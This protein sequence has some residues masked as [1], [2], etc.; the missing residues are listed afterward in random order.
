MDSQKKPVGWDIS[1]PRTSGGWMVRADILW[2][3]TIIVAL[4]A[5]A[6]TFSDGLQYMVHDWESEEYSHGYL[7]PIIAAFLIWRKKDA[8]ASAG[9]LRA[10]GEGR[11]GPRGGWAGVVL[12]FFGLL[13]TL[14]GE[15]STAVKLVQ[16]G[17]IIVLFGVAL[18]LTG[19]RGFAVIAAPM[20]YFAFM[21][22]LPDFLYTGLSGQ[23]QLIS[24][25]IGVAVIRLFDIPVYLEGNVIDL[26][27]YKLQVVEACSGLRYL[28][29]LMSFGYLCAYLY[30]GAAWHRAVLFLSTI[31]IT[32]LMNS[33]RIG[34]IGVLV[35]FWG[36]E[37][38]E[39][40][41]HL[42]EGWVI[43]MACVA[44]L[45]T[46]IWMFARFGRPRRALAAALQLDLPSF[47]W[48]KEPRRRLAGA[49]TGAWHV[50][51]TMFV[52][53]AIFT[54]AAA[55]RADSVPKRVPLVAF[56]LVF[57]E[58]LGNRKS[59][60]PQIIDIL[61]LS[62]YIIAD[63]A[64]PAG[65]PVNFLVAYY[66]SQRKGAAVHSP[67]TCIPAG[68]WE[69]ETIS[70]HRVDGVVRG[71]LVPLFVN[72]VV[73]ARGRDRQLVYYWFAQRGRDM[74]NEYV[75]KWY[76]FW[77]GLTR[78][79][80]DGAL[81]RLVTPTRPGEPVARADERLGAL[82]RKMYPVISRYIPA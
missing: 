36:I 46:E 55:Q 19:W 14:L 47:E 23:L 16:I 28:F 27:V 21:V 49:S 37:Q 82:L 79:R 59:M 34:L 68:G 56:P 75:V 57:G 26:G 77:D 3:V 13:A 76:L 40:F 29:P 1:A 7:I 58:W 39:G 48:G 73:I 69:I 72:R 15:F 33:F 18:T 20:A 2:W 80:T 66:D 60:E 22:P 61:K 11:S 10:S 64:K 41:L 24:S 4:A 32:I 52:L 70:R 50:S 81:V 8:L 5:M 9:V 25:K 62:D 44:I 78:N 53:A 65:M 35:D 6:V 67:R 42:F 51:V 43:F 74:T 54:V 30:R 31:P 17:F 71:G 12:V 63:Y 45:F 38:A